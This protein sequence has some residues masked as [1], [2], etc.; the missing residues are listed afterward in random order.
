MIVLALD[1]STNVGSVGWIKT[2]GDGPRPAVEASF[3]A[4]YA[5]APGHAETLLAKIAWALA[6]G[7][8][9]QEDVGLVVYGRGPGSF[10]GVRIGLATAKG[11]ALGLGMPILGVSSL[12]ALALS[13]DR[14]G[15]VATLVDA[16]RGEIYA[17]VYRV[18]GND[19]LPA[20][21]LVAAEQVT[22]PDGA[23]AVVES[24]SA[25]EPVLLVGDGVP[26]CVAPIELR[27]CALAL[28]GSPG[29]DAPSAILMARVGL[30]RFG[31]VGPDDPA[32]VE[33]V[34]LREPDAKLPAPR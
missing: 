8:L 20:A 12:E 28:L 34:Y 25:G 3:E 32:T 22:K 7:G 9:R 14:E 10:T 23:A 24:A 16:R 13:A 29:P 19:G 15:L 5:C 33:P 2:R 17:A 27:L 21:T 31:C 18:A 11:L 1:T 30:E 26:K 4:T 6:E